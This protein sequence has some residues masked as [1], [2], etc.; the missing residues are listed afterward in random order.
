MPGLLVSALEQRHSAPWQQGHGAGINCAAPN[1]LQDT[2]T[3]KETLVCC[4]D[5]IIAIVGKPT[6]RRVGGPK[7]NKRA[8]SPT[9]Q[10][11][12]R[13]EPWGRMSSGSHVILYMICSRPL[14]NDVLGFPS[15]QVPYP[16]KR[17]KEQAQRG[18]YRLARGEIEAQ[19]DSKPPNVFSPEYW[20][21]R[22]PSSSLCSS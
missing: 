18:R 9:T 16:A 12:E 20:M 10:R 22:K 2:W 1:N 7:R 8:Q 4:Q 6:R 21:Y 5:E 17:R 15:R 19:A 14:G 11:Q 13:S 3:G